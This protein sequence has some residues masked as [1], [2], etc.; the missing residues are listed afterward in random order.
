MKKVCKFIQKLIGSRRMRKDA[1]E[2]AYGALCEEQKDESLF[3]W[4]RD[5]LRERSWKTRQA[6]IMAALDG[7]SE[8]QVWLAGAIECGVIKM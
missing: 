3:S 5:I 6:W 4:E 7:D 2:A 8:K 1:G